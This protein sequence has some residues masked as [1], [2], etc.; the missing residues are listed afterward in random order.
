MSES[1]SVEK[2]KILLELLRQLREVSIRQ[3][4]LLVSDDL[5]ALSVTF[6]SRRLLVEKLEAVHRAF[7]AEAEG[8]ALEE[9]PGL[10]PYLQQWV[11]A[12]DDFLHQD[13]RTLEM[14]RDRMEKTGCFLVERLRA[15][16]AAEHYKK[17]V[18][19][20]HGLT[21]ICGDM[22]RFTDVKK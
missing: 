7:T 10:K 1:S 9:I 8:T 22:P 12:V 6:E 16:S 5:D 20:N 13:H 21:A 17:T 18:Q 19:A 14:L 2:L 11:T 4:N 15:K 3:Q